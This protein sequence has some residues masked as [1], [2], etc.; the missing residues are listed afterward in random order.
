M[1]YRRVRYLSCGKL[2]E[3]LENCD[4][5]HLL[6]VKL[7]F[8]NDDHNESYPLAIITTT[9]TEIPNVCESEGMV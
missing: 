5:K 8:T 2:G 4:F 3:H 7:L 9:Q 1:Y 6:P